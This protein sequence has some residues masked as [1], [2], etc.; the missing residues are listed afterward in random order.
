LKEE[1]RTVQAAHPGRRV[2]LWAQD[3]SRF[4][5]HTVQRRRLTLR[6]VKPLCP[7]EQSFENF[8]LC[9]A[10][11]PNSGEN[12]VLELPATDGDCLQIFL[13]QFALAHAQDP[14]EVQVLL[15]DNGGAHRAKALR[16]PERVLPVYLPAYCPE[17]NP[18]ERWWQELKDAVSNTLYGTL[19]ALRE[20]LDIEL[21]AWN[22]GP[23]RMCS[24]TSYPYLIDALASLDQS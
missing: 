13:D 18:I 12:F 6:G 8:W 7:F 20:R 10:V 1:L 22:H 15:M 24:L 4:G 3:E 21:A 5:L 9:G 23:E 2:C 11:A 14:E 19:D 17:L 16:W